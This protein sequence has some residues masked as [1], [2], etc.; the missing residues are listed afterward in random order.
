MPKLLQIDSCLGILST[1]KISEDIAKVAMSQGW[2]CHIMHGARYVGTTVQ[3]HYQVSS[4]FEEYI[5][6]AGSYL[7]DSHGLGSHHATKRIIK[8]IQEIK[9]DVVQL[10][11]I[12]GYYINYKDLFNYLISSDIPVVWTFHDCWAFTGHCSFFDSINCSKWKTGCHD[13]QLK[14]KYPISL[15]DRSKRNWEL[16][17]DLFNK[18]PNL[19][20]VPVSN[21]LN[22]LVRSSFLSQKASIVIHNG[23]DISR[24][25]PIFPV[26]KNKNYFVILGVA[27]VWSNRKGLND[28]IELRKR[29]PDTYRI[30]LV[31]L[32]KKQ[33]QELPMGIV[34]ISRTTNLK[35]LVKLYC[36]ADVF[37]NPTYSDNFPTTNIEA[38]ACGTPV[39]TYN[40]GGSPEAIDEKTGI[41]VAQGDILGLIKAIKQMKESPLSSDNCRKRAEDK[42][43][44]DKK[45]LKYIEIYNSLLKHPNTH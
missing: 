45:F 34:G 23:I 32:N 15:L 17:K 4:R 37:V 44:K 14:K 10:H 2:E 24:F 22:T 9:P 7:F 13:C 33:I 40:T 30:I 26:K 19:T 38:L 20:L 35:E 36:E 16:K 5:H 41:V 12:H 8:K 27:A 21:W 29:L 3:Q 1:G 25:R 6:Y 43:D 42:Y 39:I 11:C 31:G 28:F 18:M